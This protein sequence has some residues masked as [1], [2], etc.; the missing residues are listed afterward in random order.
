MFHVNSCNVCD[1]ADLFITH[2]T[3][4]NMAIFMSLP[5]EMGE[6]CKEVTIPQD[7]KNL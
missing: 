3:C 4:L 6:L 7:I 5:R 1:L 2:I